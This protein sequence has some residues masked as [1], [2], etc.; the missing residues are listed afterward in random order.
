MH[1]YTCIHILCMGARQSLQRAFKA[2]DKMYVFVCECV[3]ECVSVRERERERSSFSQLCIGGVDFLR[4]TIY[5][6]QGT[7]VC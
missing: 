4:A 6:L 5:G 3:R 2:L 7:T 1:I